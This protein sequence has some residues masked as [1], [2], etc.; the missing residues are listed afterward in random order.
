ME[1]V[2]DTLCEGERLTDG[3]N[4]PLMSSSSN[5]VIVPHVTESR[6]V[7]CPGARRINTD[8]SS[9]KPRMEGTIQTSEA[10]W[11]GNVCAQQ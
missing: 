1:P 6:A 4:A 7:C 2:T 11:T 5:E 8:H 3:W 10:H 9:C